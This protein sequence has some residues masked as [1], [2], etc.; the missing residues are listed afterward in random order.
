MSIWESNIGSKV[1]GFTILKIY[2]EMIFTADELLNIFEREKWKRGHFTYRT[3]PQA[4]Q[5]FAKES[6]EH[7]RKF[8]QNIF[9]I[10]KK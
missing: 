7:S 2:K 10:M 6:V 1:V 3:I 5:P 8:L 4:N 9:A